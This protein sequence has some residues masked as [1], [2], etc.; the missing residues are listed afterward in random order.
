[1][2]NNWLRIKTAASIV[3]LLTVCALSSVEAANTGT[4]R[5]KVMDVD[6]KDALPGASILVKGTSIG[7]STDL[8][9]NYVIQNVPTGDQT[10]VVSYVGYVAITTVV[11][12]AESGETVMDF[13]MTAT[14]ITSKNVLVT[15]QA[16]GQME[17]INQQLSANHIVNVVS[18]EKMKELPDANIA[19]SIGRLPGI[20]LQRSAGEAY[21]V[22]VRGLSPKY[23]EVTIEGVPMSSTN[24]Y[25]RGIDLS[26]LGDDLV[27]GVEVSKTLSA[28]M[29]ADALGGTV[30]LTLR[31]ADAGLHYD[32]WGNGGYNKLRDSYGNYKFAG[33]VGDRF[34]NDKVGILVLGSA[35][36]KQLPSDQFSAT[37]AVPIYSSTARQFSVSTQS[38]QLTDNTTKRHRY[39]ASAIID[40]ASDFVDL[41]LL[42]IFDQKSDS[43]ITRSFTTNFNQNNFYNQTYINET[44]TSQRTHSLQANFKFAGTELPISLSYTRSDQRVPNGLEFDIQQTNIPA[45]PSSAMIY[46]VPST[47][48]KDYTGVMNP[49]SPTSTMANMLSNNIALTDI[50]YDIKADWRIPFTLSDALSGKVSV[51]GKYHNVDRTSSRTQTYLYLQYGAGAGNRNRLIADFPFLTGAANLQ[52][53]IGAAP[54]T[55]H[56]YDRT[57]ILGYPIGPGHDVYRMANMYNTDYAANKSTY[58]QNGLNSYNQNYIDKESSTAGY[59]KVDLNVGSDLT[60]VPGIRYQE[61]NTD[62]S[63]Y[64]IVANPTNQNG[65]TGTPTFAENKR[66]NPNWFPSVNIKYKATD[67]VQLMGAAYRSVSLPSYGQVNPLVVYQPSTAIVSNNPLLKPSTAWNFDIGGS[68]FSDAIGLFTVDFFYKEIT[69]LIYNMQNYY[70]L[71]PYPLVGAPSDIF[72]RLPD[73]NY[74]D[75]AQVVLNRE[76]GLAMSIPMNDPD[77]AYLRGVEFSWQTH[78][79]YLPGL[80]SG[81][82]LDLNLSLMSSNQMYPWFKVVGPA[83]GNKDTLVYTTTAGSLQDQPKAIYNAILGWDYKGFSSR[84]SARYQQLT[85]TS[86]DTR[87]GLENSYYDNVLLIDISVKQQLITGLSVFANITN[88]NSHIDNYYF[89]HPAYL[90]YAAGQ[91]P[92]SQQTYGWALQ[93]G[94]SYFY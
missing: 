91:L 16:R 37:Y 48:I 64:H 72:D 19:E 29:D 8:D 46:G 44:N 59:L 38:A 27:K 32:V 14:A 47:L 85:L 65:L 67:N 7:A 28:D 20:S 81:L 69:D 42:N 23:N 79:W 75:S 5:G 57:N 88:I 17:S 22:V 10:L 60:I 43:N 3:A 76:A 25:D 84:F 53:G 77:K 13:N 6:T 87:Y 94:L 11:K 74:F 4:L 33:S 45:I 1:M 73:K 24:Y 56:N 39:G 70:A 93:F 51:G 2:L 55:D 34:L 50:S 21:A 92:T 35:E 80:L 30:N 12:I 61:E 89:S 71:S 18:A 63:A 82:V 15:A 26:L 40:Y 83:I 31:T 41:K 54:F 66:D 49:N 62:I 52:S 78:M 68:V 90:A 86:M 36:L 9:G 58:W